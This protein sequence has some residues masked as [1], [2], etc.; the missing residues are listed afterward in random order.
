MMPTTRQAA[1]ARAGRA[2]AIAAIL[3]TWLA[4]AS[5][6]AQNETPREPRVPEAEAAV[7]PVLRIV[8]PERRIIPPPALN[9]P[10]STPLSPGDQLQMQL[11]RDE[12]QTRQ[13]RLEDRAGPT[14]PFAGIEALRNQQQL[15]RANNILNGR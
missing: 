2:L 8:P 4:G 10:P 9:A 6:G 13:R 15:N 1:R 5:A 14:N 7:P 11:Y 12:L 3:A